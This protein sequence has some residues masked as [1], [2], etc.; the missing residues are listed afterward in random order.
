MI[1]HWGGVRRRKDLARLMLR[2]SAQMSMNVWPRVTTAPLSRSASTPRA[3]SAVGSA[4]ALDSRSQ[5]TLSATVNTEEH[6]E[7][8]SL[9]GGVCTAGQEN[10]EIKR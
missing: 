4:A 3:P 2:L 8:V 5:T 7:K 1:Q 9:C 6:A 10:V